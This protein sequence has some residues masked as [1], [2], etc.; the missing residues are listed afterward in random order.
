MLW[1]CYLDVELWKNKTTTNPSRRHLRGWGEGQGHRWAR[2]PWR[3]RCPCG[4]IL[5][6]TV[7]GQT[8]SRAVGRG[9]AAR[10]ARAGHELV[11]ALHRH[12]AAPSVWTPRVLSHINL[13]KDQT[14]RA[15]AS[16]QQ[17]AGS[18]HCCESVGW[19]VL[20]LP[21]PQPRDNVSTC[22]TPRSP[23]AV[24]GPTE[25]ILLCLIAAELPWQS[26]KKTLFLL[27]SLLLSW[28]SPED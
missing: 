25:E 17:P 2:C 7:H 21:C 3:A 11:V 27:H 14:H 28:G 6:E 26:D 4:E 1:D 24:S 16:L 9:L 18:R 23:L 20:K 8:R 5:A 10:G 22:E 19:E 12:Q 15:C 13:S